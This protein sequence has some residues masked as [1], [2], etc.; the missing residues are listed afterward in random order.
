MFR[1]AGV[2]FLA[3]A[4]AW[5]VM[6]I[7]SVRNVVGTGFRGN[8]VSSNPEEQFLKAQLARRQADLSAKAGQESGNLKESKSRLE[9][10]SAVAPTQSVPVATTRVAPRASD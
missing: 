1:V 6:S 9:Q 8:V 3:A 2:L 10:L 7:P 4:T 5:V